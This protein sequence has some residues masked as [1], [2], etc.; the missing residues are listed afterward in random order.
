MKIYKQGEYTIAQDEKRAFAVVEKNQN[1]YKLDDA[2]FNSMFDRKKLRFVR[3]DKDN[4]LYMSGMALTIIVTLV[5]YFRSTSYSIIDVNFL[6]ATVVLIGNIFIHEF[7]H[8]LF[9]KLF[10][11]KSYVKIGFKFVFIWPAFYVDTSYSYMVSKYKR[12]A[13][14]L[15]GNFMNCIYV[16]IILSLF[17]EQ[18]PYC[19]LVITNILINFIPIIKSDGYYATITLLDKTNKRKGKA[20]TTIEDFVRGFAMFVVLNTF[21]WLSQ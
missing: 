5:L 8:V 2:T 10:Y 13:I 16:L 19:Y 1:F 4:I 7:G 9:L 6:P 11:K 14:Y 12:I 20:A 3:T 21:S 18:L 17:P 15:A